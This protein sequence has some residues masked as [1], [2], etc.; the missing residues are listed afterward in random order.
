M[1]GNPQMVWQGRRVRDGESTA[2]GG[3]GFRVCF[4]AL[5]VAIQPTDGVNF[6]G[7]YIHL[8]PEVKV[9]SRSSRS[10]CCTRPQDA[11]WA[12]L[13]NVVITQFFPPVVHN[14]YSPPEAG[15][16]WGIWGS[17]YNIPKAIVYLLKGDYT[18]KPLNPKP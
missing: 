10:Q 15:R 1:S 9:P 8:N 14:M 13:F 12:I 16:I 2:F 18:P 17:Y 4:V 5:L 7:P 11:A 3:L 6:T